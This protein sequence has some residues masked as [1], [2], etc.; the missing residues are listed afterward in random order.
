MMSSQGDSEKVAYY[1]EQRPD[2]TPLSDNEKATL[3]LLDY[4]DIDSLI[5]ID[6]TAKQLHHKVHERGGGNGGDDVVAHADTDAAASAN[7]VKRVGAS[8]Y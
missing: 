1:Y 7:A 8:S 3:D 2:A 4:P 5:K 6:E